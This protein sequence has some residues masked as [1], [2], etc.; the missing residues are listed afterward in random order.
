MANSQP[1]GSQGARS[2]QESGSSTIM[3][4]IEVLAESS[5]SWEDAAQQ[6]VNQASKTLHNIR[7]VYIKEQTAQVDNGNIVSYRINAKITFE[8]ER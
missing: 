6:A 4:V 1:Q 5:K 2:P 8:L 7:S 3:K